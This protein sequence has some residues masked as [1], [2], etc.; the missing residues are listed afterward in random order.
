MAEQALVVFTPSGRRGRVP[1]GTS[2]LKAARDL[3]VDID[4]VCGGHGI[5]GHCQVTVSIGEFPKLGMVSSERH[6]STRGDVEQRFE[7]RAGLAEGRRLSCRASV[8]GDVVVD[9]PPESQVHRQIVR[10]RADARAIE[11]DPL[12]RLHYLKL[13]A[14]TLDDQASDLARV[15]RA[16]AAEWSL[17]IADWHWS[18]LHALPSALRSGDWTITV[19]VREARSVVGVWPGFRDRALGLAVDVGTTT[20]AAHLCDLASGNV[21]ASVGAM[22]PQIRF[23]EDIMSR[24]SFIQLN[25]DDATAPTAVVRDAIGRLAAEAAA[26]SGADTADIIEMAIVGNPTMH[27]LLLGLDPSSLGQAPFTLVTDDAMTVAGRDLDLAIHPAAHAYVLPCIAGHV[28]ADAAGVLLSEAPHRLDAMTLIVDIGTNAEIVLGNRERLLACSS[29]TGPAFEG[30]QISC[31]QRAAPGAIERV[32]ID[33]TTLAPRFK[34]IGCDT[35][36]DEPGFA[37]DVAAVGVTGICGSGIVEAVAE[38]Y[39]AGIVTTSGLV[40][41]AGITGCPHLVPSGK[42]FGYQL[43]PGPPAISITQHDVRA[44]QLAKAALYAGARLLMDRMAVDT[45]DRIVLS[46]AFGS[47]ID[48][49]YAMALG[50]IPDCDPEKV[51]AAGNAAGTGARIALLN[52]AARREIEGLARQVEKVDTAGAT[53]FQDYFVAA[54]SIPHSVDAFPNAARALGTNLSGTTKASEH[55]HQES[56]S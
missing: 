54:M 40:D 34:V 56:L 42:A 43:Y 23:G 1:V 25:S 22:N 6:V 15:A 30:A 26:E 3:G 33:R 10:K 51:S 19:A 9:V 50:M 31:G 52:K 17:D 20:I 39:L 2:L 5:C 13:A 47:Y 12:V 11:V 4:S 48:A 41:G 36:S 44:I 27:H 46:G 28:G 45:V 18:A 55:Q 32:R 35:W 8:L 16:L 49:R 37:R 29:P 14:P 24:L 7:Q 38:M 21:I 53:R